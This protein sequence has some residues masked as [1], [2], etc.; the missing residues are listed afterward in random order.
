[1]THWYLVSNNVTDQGPPMVKVQADSAE[2]ALQ[3]ARAFGFDE[4][5]CVLD[6]RADP[7]MRRH[8]MSIAFLFQVA[9]SLDELGGEAA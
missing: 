5:A 2:E 3:R 4:H 6:E 1:M 9:P 7:G 8:G